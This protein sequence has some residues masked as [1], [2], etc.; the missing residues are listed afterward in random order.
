VDRN[1]ETIILNKN[2]CTGGILKTQELF[3]KAYLNDKPIYTY[4]HLFMGSW[5]QAYLDSDIFWFGTVESVGGFRHFA[6]WR[7]GFK[8]ATFLIAPKEKHLLGASFKLIK[9]LATWQ[10]LIPTSYEVFMEPPYIIVAPE[11]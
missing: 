7:H 6:F 11:R 1:T 10:L 4:L 5:V 3:P 2:C 8:L 9:N